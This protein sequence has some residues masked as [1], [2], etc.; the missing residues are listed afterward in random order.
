M[1]LTNDN[2]NE[3]QLLKI[4]IKYINNTKD[5]NKTLHIVSKKKK[6]LHISVR[7]TRNNDKLEEENLL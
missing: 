5:S 3:N 6:K 1:E 7:C 2:Y 4:K